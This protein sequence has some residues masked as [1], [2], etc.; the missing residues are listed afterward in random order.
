MT[1]IKQY[2]LKNNM[3]WH[4]FLG[5]A[6]GLTLISFQTNYFKNILGNST[7][8]KLRL[9]YH[10]IKLQNG[11]SILIPHFHTNFRG[12]TPNGAHLNLNPFKFG[13]HIK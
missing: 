13:E 9:D 4:K 10:Y 5:W 7:N 6:G 3:E 12:L 2:F 1:K 11:K 8:F